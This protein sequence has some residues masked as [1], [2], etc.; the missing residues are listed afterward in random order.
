MRGLGRGQRYSGAGRGRRLGGHVLS[1]RGHLKLGR[2]D[3][4][5]PG[6]LGVHAGTVPRTSRPVFMGPAR[7]NHPS[8]LHRPS[9]DGRLRIV[10]LNPAAGLG[11]AE[12]CLLDMM[13]AVRRTDASH[14]LHLVVSSDGPLVQRSRQLGASVT[15]LPMP[16]ELTQLGDSALKGSSRSKAILEFGTRGIRAGWATWQYVRSL[17]RTLNQLKPDVIH[18]NG[19]KFHLLA[20]AAQKS[21]AALIWH[22]HDFLSLRPL[23]AR[24]LRLA[25]TR[26]SGA[27]AISRAVQ[28]DAKK[29]LR[30][31]PVELI[32]NGI[33][34][35]EFSTLPD[36]CVCLDE[37]AGLPR[38]HAETV[39]IGLVA[40]FA[41]WKGH[42]VFLQAA[43][44]IVNA[45]PQ[46]ETRFYIVGEPI[47]QTRGS[48]YSTDELREIASSLNL[49][50]RVGFIP[51]QRNPAD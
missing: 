9:E 48:Q 21:G 14:D 40:T 5:G 12:R 47:Y 30:S 38:G 49:T 32:Y 6:R 33:D 1:R 35:D 22:I 31:L 4:P 37:L 51:F 11:G 27:I 23:V 18:S 34:T 46:L 17:T 28:C 16:P 7:S 15:V 42:E 45:Q 20:S 26:A 39:R 2:N 29:V 10:Y 3:Y 41:R 24:G 43:S 44:Q 8:S 25:A 50:S 19:I 13:G 36:S